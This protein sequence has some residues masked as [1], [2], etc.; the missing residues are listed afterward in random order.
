[1]ELQCVRVCVCA[2]TFDPP[3]T[4]GS[5]FIHWLMA[6]RLLQLNKGEAMKEMSTNIHL[7]MAAAVQCT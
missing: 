1:M 2:A 4:K 3:L 7:M 6:A 5:S